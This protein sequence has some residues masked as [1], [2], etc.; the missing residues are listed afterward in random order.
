MFHCNRPSHPS[1]HGAVLFQ[2]FVRPEKRIHGVMVE[3]QRMPQQSRWILAVFTP[4]TSVSNPQMPK[5]LSFVFDRLWAYLQSWSFPEC[6]KLLQQSWDHAV[7]GD[8]ELCLN[9]RWPCKD[10][11]IIFV[12]WP[13][14]GRYDLRSLM[15][16]SKGCWT[17]VPWPSTHKNSEQVCVQVHVCFFLILSLVNIQKTMENHHF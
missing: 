2:P 10:P 1:V 14:K 16:W 6:L 8:C 17:R 11:L 13:S 5:T 3:F 12:F 7:D 9:C 4:Q 15:R